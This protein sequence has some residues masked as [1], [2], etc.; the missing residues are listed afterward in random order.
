MCSSYKYVINLYCDVILIQAC[1]KLYMYKVCYKCFILNAG[2][3]I[4]AMG[5]KW[6]PE[7]FNCAFCL[8]LLNKG[9]FK[10]HRHN[11]YCQPCYIKLFG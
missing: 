11:P 7:H 4:T 3:C 9:T 6:H 8:K 1:N 2:K 5:K 10:E